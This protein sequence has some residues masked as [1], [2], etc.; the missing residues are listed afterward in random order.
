MQ[1]AVVM[2]MKLAIAL[3]P[4]L[5][6][7]GWLQYVMVGKVSRSEEDR[8]RAGLKTAV[9]RFAHSFD[10]ELTQVWI[11]FARPP[12]KRD[13]DLA[14][15]LSVQ[16]DAWRE[17]TDFPG[18][19]Q[20]IYQI[21]AFHKG[22][23]DIS[24]FNP[25]AAIFEDC[26]WPES[27][28]PLQ[29]TFGEQGHSLE[30]L[31]RSL[32]AEP[33]IPALL[34]P[35]NMRRG[36]HVP[37]SVLVVVLDTDY[38]KDVLFP[39]L[40]ARHIN[41]EGRDD[42][43]V[44]IRGVGEV[45]PIL[46]RSSPAA[47]PGSVDEA[48]PLFAIRHLISG[49]DQPDGHLRMRGMGRLMRHRTP[50]PKMG[51]QMLWTL[52]ASHRAGSLEKYVSLNRW[53]NLAL[54]FIVMAILTVSVA[55]LVRSANRAKRLAQRQLEFV[56]GVSHELLTPLAAIRSAGQNLSDGVVK[57]EERVRRY[58]G[59]IEKEG[60]RL[61][62]LVE[63]VLAFA[64][65]QSARDTYDMVELSLPAVLDEVILDHQVVLSESSFQVDIAVP[66]QLPLIWAD[67]AALKKVMANLIANAVKYARNDPRLFI[68]ATEEGRFVSLE[69]E[70]RGPGVNGEDLPHIF[71]P[72][73]RGKGVRDAQIK[74]S[75]LGLCLV[76][77]M[78]SAHGGQVLVLKAEGGG[79][80]FKTTWPISDKLPNH[81]LARP[82]KMK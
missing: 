43:I 58:G 44:T 18:M 42:F 15:H 64:G 76:R 33:T 62:D 38:L 57:Q 75:G 81:K 31:V 20:E 47:N 2:H 11:R 39:E 60:G 13:V 23:L 29:N 79:S 72:F 4:M 25:T 10:R 49:D 17:E 68:R 34:V 3:I 53:Q 22:A 65:M 48:T 52:E 69:I 21:T 9:T 24:R 67:R 37:D 63:Q 70:D 61:A 12:A 45:R 32:M 71:E 80:I 51:A 78:V 36:R 26:L 74:G 40:T 16:L 27:F 46:F 8:T 14:Q 7:L 59:M 77:N 55:L 35:V 73:Y 82:L 19:I 66:K 28:K 30:H 50:D 6:F 41:P 54:N 5:L 1:G 56:A